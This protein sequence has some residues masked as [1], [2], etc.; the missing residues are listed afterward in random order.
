MNTAGRSPPRSMSSCPQA[1]R[2]RADRSGAGAECVDRLLVELRSMAEQTHVLEV[3][4]TIRDTL[5]RR[6]SGPWPGED[7]VA[8]ADADLA[9]MRRILNVLTARTELIIPAIPQWRAGGMLR[10]FIAMAVLR[11]PRRRPPTDG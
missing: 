7:I 2:E 1:E 10:L 8:I 5:A 11:P 6:W 9:T 4:R 3:T